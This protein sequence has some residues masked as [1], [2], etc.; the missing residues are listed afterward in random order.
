MTEI[1]LEATGLSVSLTTSDLGA[2]LTWYSDVL[3][4]AVEREFERSGVP[5]AVRMRSGSVA[6][7]LTQ[8]NGA[9]GS[10]RVKGEGFS[11]RLTTKQSIDDLASR[12]KAHGAAL[13]SEPAD[14]WGARV[15]RL[16][17]PDGF[18]LVISSEP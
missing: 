5:F 10:Q 11:F 12:A 17:D 9:R 15:F 16:R 14:G 7:L 3:G 1:L 8:D 2:S 18:L 6:L 4:F 13:E